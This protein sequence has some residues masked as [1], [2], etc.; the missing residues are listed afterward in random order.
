LIAQGL[1]IS[2]HLGSFPDAVAAMPD[3]TYTLFGLHGGQP[4]TPSSNTLNAAAGVETDADRADGPHELPTMGMA[5]IRAGDSLRHVMAGGGGWG[6]PL[7]RDVDA[8]L[9]DLRD[10]KITPGYAR[11]MY[12]VV[13]DPVTLTIDEAATLRERASRR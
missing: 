3:G 5:P 6:D 2:L 8:V 9:A 12:G 10:E 4:G 11:E 1:T 7:N 13:V